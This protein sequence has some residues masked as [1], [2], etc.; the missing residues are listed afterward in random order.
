[1]EED[2]ERKS[3]KIQSQV[4]KHCASRQKQHLETLAPTRSPPTPRALLP[5][6]RPRSRLDSREHIVAAGELLMSEARPM[7]V[8]GDAETLSFRISRGDHGDA[9]IT[10]PAAV[11][12][13]QYI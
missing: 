7:R 6:L 2:K 5:S 1:M 11:G 9:A 4:R 12:G 10:A 3:R 8:Q 13:W